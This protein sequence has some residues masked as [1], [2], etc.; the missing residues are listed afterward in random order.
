MCV[1]VAIV[2]FSAAGPHLIAALPVPAGGSP[3]R[4]VAAARGAS[5]GRGEELEVC[6]W[7]YYALRRLSAPLAAWRDLAAVRRPKRAEERRASMLDFSVI[8][9]GQGGRVPRCVHSWIP[10][11]AI[12]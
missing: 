5:L 8:S 1:C 2:A 7:E 11:S 6:A 9:G 3:W 12:L 4:A 10:V